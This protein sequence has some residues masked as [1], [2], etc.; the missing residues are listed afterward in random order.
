MYEQKGHFVEHKTIVWV[1][2]FIDRHSLAVGFMKDLVVRSSICPPET[3]EEIV[4]KFGQSLPG[5]V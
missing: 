1:A 2:S 5:V 4:R 3:Q